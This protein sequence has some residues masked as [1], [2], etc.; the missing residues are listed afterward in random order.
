MFFRCWCS[1]ATFFMMVHLD[2]FRQSQIE[3]IVYKAELLNT[4]KVQYD[5]AVSVSTM[6]NVL[7]CLIACS[8]N[9]KCM[10]FMYN[11]ELRV[12]IQHLKT[13]RYQDPMIEEFGWKMYLYTESMCNYFS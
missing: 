1:F 11:G 7:G 2:I 5:G 13:F 8:K 4:G 10:T 12:C 3:A 6:G 9:E